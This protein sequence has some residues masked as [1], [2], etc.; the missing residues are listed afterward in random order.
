MWKGLSKPQQWNTVDQKVEQ[1][2][3]LE[4]IISLSE[5]KADF[6][7][8]MFIVSHCHS[9][10]WSTWSNFTHISSNKTWFNQNVNYFIWPVEAISLASWLTSSEL[11]DL[12]G[13]PWNTEVDF[14]VPNG[15]FILPLG[16]VIHYFSTQSNLLPSNP[17]FFAWLPTNVNLTFLRF[18]PIFSWS[19]G[20]GFEPR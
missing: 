15:R 19:E 2:I 14:Y 3:S 17:L 6:C 12:L 18:L 10:V 11:Q 1:V 9:A 7:S 8:Q 16:I 13:F 20:W 4:G 5:Q